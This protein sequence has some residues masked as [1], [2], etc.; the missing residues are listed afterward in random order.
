M[1]QSTTEQPVAT[2][3]SDTL[4][5]IGAG[6]VGLC[7]AAALKAESIRYAHV[8]AADGVGGNWRHGV[9]ASANLV[10]SKRST[11]FEDYPMPACYP[12]F[13]S[14]AEMLAYVEDYARAKGV[15]EGIELGKEVVSAAPDANGRWLVELKDGERRL[16]KGV[17]VCNGHHWDR[18]YPELP[19]TLGVPLLHS[20]DYK[21]PA[22]LTGKR[23]LTIGGG[24]SGCDVA[25][26]AGRVGRA[27]DI[28]LRSGHWYLPRMFLGWPLTDLPIWWLP[29]PIQRLLLKAIIALSFGRLK[30]YGIPPPEHRIFERHP[31]FGGEL[32][33]AIRLGRVKV[34]PAIA[35]CE[36]RRVHFTDGSS[37]EYD[38]VVAATG[39]KLSFPFLPEG[40]VKVDGVV[41]KVYSG[42][43]PPGVRNLYIVGWTQA[44]NGLGRLMT[45]A[46]RLYARMIKMQDEVEN[47][48]GSILATSFTQRLPTT[49]L[50]DP[51]AARWRIWAA[52]FLF[53]LLKRYDLRLT[54]ELKAGRNPFQKGV[55]P[56]IGGS[57]G[58]S[59]D[60]PTP[61]VP[62]AS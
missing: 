17:V 62:Q 6:P 49:H 44:R 43:F 46:S 39:F 58:G 18:R 51:E 2:D 12:D 45:P 14:A 27:S 8:E 4:L 61:G 31:A 38:L 35:R 53:P 47:P 21:S 19:G 3:L 24:N 7:M 52:P 41:A 60:A 25:C 50:V 22:Q 29:V 30:R 36:G 13:P 56:L 20:K 34:R 11:E 55:G 54:R 23:V 57:S 33:N 1:L 48:L 16:Y 15:A 10:S 42:A 40:L 9:Y 59:G 32:L 26:E 28:S 37:A 5:V